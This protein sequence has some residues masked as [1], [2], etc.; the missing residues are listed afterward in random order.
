MSLQGQDEA[1][2]CSTA[3]HRVSAGNGDQGEGGIAPAH[4]GL[5]GELVL[6]KYAEDA[7]L[8]GDLGGGDDDGVHFCVGG[9]QA[10]HAAFQIEAFE[11]GFGSS[12]EGDDDFSLAGGAGALDE[13]VVAVDD[14][15][16]AHGFATNL[17]GEDFA[18]ADD[19][20]EG[21]ALRVFDGFN[22]EAGGDA[23][24]E[25]QA[26][27]GAGAA[28]RGQNIERAAAVVGA[29][30]EAL[31]LEVGDVLVDGGQRFEAEA[32]GDFLIG[33]GIAV[34]LDE[35]GDEVENLFLPPGD[36]HGLSIAKKKRIEGEMFGR[37]TERRNPGD[38]IGMQGSGDGCG[39][40][41]PEMGRVFGVEFQ[42]GQGG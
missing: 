11:G 25:G 4:V 41:F 10:D 19:V 40:G 36:G 7:A 34:A 22:G 21:D 5:T 12:D 37:G 38:R 24:H 28:A 14:V 26:V 16:V 29:R 33:G 3:A 2:V 32:P 23:A 31:V 6:A 35:T 42:N 39:W 18:I 9:L 13:N 15:L 17:E 1:P 27:G 20:A 8:D 30:D